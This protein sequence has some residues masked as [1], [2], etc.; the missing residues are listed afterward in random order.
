MPTYPPPLSDTAPDILKSHTS[1][2]SSKIIPF[3][4]HIWQTPPKKEGEITKMARIIRHPENLQYL[5]DKTL[6][7]VLLYHNLNNTPGTKP[8]IIDGITGETVFTYDSFRTGVRRLARHLVHEIGIQQGAV[9]SIL[10]TNKASLSQSLF[11]FFLLS[12]PFPFRLT[13]LWSKPHIWDPHMHSQSPPTPTPFV[14]RSQL[15]TT[16]ENNGQPRASRVSRWQTCY[17]S[18]PGGGG[19][20]CSSYSLASVCFNMLHV[21]VFSVLMSYANSFT[22]Q[23]AYIAFSPLVLWCLR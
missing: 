11:I 13:I 2:Y 12:Y 6:T 18:P 1:R 20:L 23:L 14:P 19:G 4:H 9:V 16:L 22:T 3:S 17:R 8:A 15:H 5:E 21:Q 10:S 7:Q